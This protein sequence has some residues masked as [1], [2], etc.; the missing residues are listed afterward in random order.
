MDGDRETEIGRQVA[1]DLVPESAGIVASHDI[2]MFLHEQGIWM[3]G[4]IAMLWTQC[5]TSASG[6]GSS[7]GESRPLLIG[8]QLNPPSSVRNTPAAE[9]A[10]RFAWILRIKQNGVQAHPAG[11]RLPEIAFDI[12]QSGELLPGLPAIVE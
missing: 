4:C 8:F 5:P 10:R 1:A 9:M 3:R 2:P 12:P 6:S 7:K 11:S